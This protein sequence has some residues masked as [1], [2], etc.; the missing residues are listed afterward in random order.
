MFSG[1]KFAEDHEFLISVDDQ[2]F[3][4]HYVEVH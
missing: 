3:I 1:G 2:G 4:H